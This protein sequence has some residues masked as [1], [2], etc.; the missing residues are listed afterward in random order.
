MFQ[1]MPA[2]SVRQMIYA[3]MVD[4]GGFPVRQ[5]LPS[6]AMEQVDP[7]LLLHHAD[8]K[9]PH[10]IPPDKAG[11][12]PH[13]H[14]GFSPVT[15]IFKGGIHHR[16]SQG[17]DSV[18]YA[19]GAQ[20][21]NAG[22]GIIHSERP[23]HDIHEHG[24]RQEFIQLWVNTPSRHKMDQP[25]Y[26]PVEA[27]QAPEV[28]SEDGMV[29]GSVFA[30]EV[31]G[32]KG[33]VPTHTPINAA[34]FVFK[35]GGELNVPL[36]DNHNVLIYLLDG[37]LNLPGYGFAEGLHLV[38]YNNDGSGIVLQAEE[39]TRILLLSGEPLREEV[40]SY[41]PFVMN[42]HTEILE[43]IRDYQMGKMGILIEE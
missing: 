23:P 13:P 32:R 3:Q 26:V 5:P 39:N 21:M 19:G 43:A 29:T 37:K 12:G 22:R 30:G 17:N 35:K 34:T 28:K 7:F 20:W 2:R 42:T 11:V 18:I 24:G 40:V 8:V 4:M 15:F 6:T 33:P 9:V 27:G 1:T 36:P 31:L 16:D 25:L 41:G 14:R 10:H 38:V